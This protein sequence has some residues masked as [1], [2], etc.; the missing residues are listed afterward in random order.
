MTRTTL[1]ALAE[2][3]EAAT[4]ADSELDAEIA[5]SVGWYRSYYGADE[6]IVWRSPDDTTFANPLR[7]TA[8]LDAAMS[9]VP[10]G[11]MQVVDLTLGWNADD[12]KEWPAVTVRWYPP[13]NTGN[14][15][16]A[17]IVTA[18]T[19]ALAICIAALRAHST[20]MEGKNDD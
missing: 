18:A 16:H 11:Q 13:G 8:S 1:L 2:R 6:R 5:I 12:P 7:Y 20:G 17:M 9:L 10:S 14:D 4:G 15:W 3:V 19:P